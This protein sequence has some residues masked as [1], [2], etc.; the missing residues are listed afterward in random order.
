[1][2]GIPDISRYLGRPQKPSNARAK[3]RKTKKKGRRH[4]HRRAAS[5]DTPQPPTAHILPPPPS[6]PSAQLFNPRLP[7][8]VKDVLESS[9]A[10]GTI[11]NY[12]S[13]VR[14]FTNFCDTN[15]IHN[16]LRLPADEFVLCTFGA[17]LAR[18]FSGSY[19][20]SIFSGLK[21]W[22]SFNNAEWKGG[23]RLQLILR[24]VTRLAPD[25]S[26]REPRQAITVEMLQSLRSNL[27]LASPSDAAILAVALVAF[28][29]QC[30]LGELLGSSRST[31]DP[32]RFPSRSSIGTS[33]SAKGSRELR[34][35][36]TKTNQ[37]MGETITITRQLPDVDAITALDHHLSL[38]H[39]IPHDSH[40]FAYYIPEKSRP[41]IPTKESF[42]KRVNDIWT[43]NGFSHTTGHAFR[44][45]GTTALLKA[46]V[47]PDI[48]R[49]MGRW[50]SDAFLRYWRDVADIAAK[51]AE[52]IP[53]LHDSVSAK[54]PQ[55]GRGAVSRSPRSLRKPRD[56][57]GRSS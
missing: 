23:H 15:N 31:H 38:S 51:H 47:P 56:P 48:V 20:Q 10:K 54:S 26:R 7:K 24:G 11:A 25:S 53:Y 14:T 30:R 18:H 57:K 8:I 3:P 2:S 6:P 49:Q 34:L 46:G 44:I 52:L 5:P 13:A 19:A 55:V 40:L 27:D 28:W 4:D 17:S 36:R 21:A 43:R 37:N 35:P 41:S 9:L 12:Q 42:L 45:G 39:S 50:S 33:V 22:H 1:M 16:S 32:S 29:G